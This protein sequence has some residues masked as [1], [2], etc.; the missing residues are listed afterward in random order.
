MFPVIICVLRDGATGIASNQGKI[1]CELIWLSGEKDLVSRY[2][3]SIIASITYAGSFAMRPDLGSRME[4]MLLV[5]V[6]TFFVCFGL[7]PF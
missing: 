6:K 3:S 5:D 4:E 2:S 1:T 7:R